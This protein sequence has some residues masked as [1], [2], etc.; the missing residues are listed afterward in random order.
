MTDRKDHY[1]KRVQTTELPQQF[2]VFDTETKPEKVNANTISNRLWFGWACYQRRVSNEVWCKPCWKRFERPGDF[3]HWLDNLTREGTK[4]YFLCHNANFDLPVL[5]VFTQ[6]A[7]RG[8]KLERAIIDSPPTILKWRKGRATLQFL[9]TLN[10]WREKLEVIGESLGV[11]KL[12]MPAKNASKE[13]WDTYCRR[14]VEIL[15]Q[16][17]M[18]WFETI[19]QYDLG[20]FAPT[21]ASQSMRWWRHKHLNHQVLVHTNK[22]A[23]DLERA[24]YFGGRNECW[25]LGKVKGKVYYLD[26][27]SAYPSVMHDEKFPV[28]LLGVDYGKSASAL[29]LLSK[30]FGVVAEVYVRC[31]VPI[32]PK[33]IEHKLC[34]PVGTFWCVLTGPEILQLLQVGEVLDVGWSAAFYMEPIFTT[35]IDECWEF[36]HQSKLRKD[37]CQTKFFKTLGNSLYGKF[38]QNGMKWDSD[39]WEPTLPD[40]CWIEYDN[41]TNTITRCRRLAGLTQTKRTESEAYESIPSIASYVTAY[42]RVRLWEFCKQCGLE[43][44]LYLDT[45]GV[46]V[47]R[48]GYMR[49]KKQ[50][51][52]SKLGT[53]K[54]EGVSNGMHIRGCKDY[55]F[56]DKSKT[57]GVRANAVWLDEATV[58]QQQWSSLRGSLRR[59]SVEQQTIR[60]VTK[61]LTRTYN[62]GRITTGN[63]IRPLTLYEDSTQHLL[64]RP[65]RRR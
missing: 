56:G 21:I 15:R 61:H 46:F 28:R 17:L 62:K 25:Q 48:D 40:M 55:A 22:E 24:S 53:V 42:Q 20:G 51:D 18:R 7:K 47:T 43:N 14:D 59:N 35:F 38:G 34:F 39:R 9:D 41:D 57:K 52:G 19:K 29:P 11:S 12:P 44:V 27:T 30:G 65:A 2:V 36:R 49:V 8:W 33:L 54:L 6:L 45:D 26:Y 3:W 37:Q 4:L 64:T 32:L 13:E 58:T 23:L 31:E 10:W 60:K 5:Q 50:L 16:V 1:L 63:R